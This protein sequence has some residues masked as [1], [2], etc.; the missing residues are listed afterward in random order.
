MRTYK[1][2]GQEHH[3]YDL[4]SELPNDIS[5]IK[6]WRDGFPGDWVLTED[7]AYIQILERKDIGDKEIFRTCIG[8]YMINGHMEVENL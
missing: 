5:P 7:N 2:K 8:T 3:V 6:N 1:V 4:E